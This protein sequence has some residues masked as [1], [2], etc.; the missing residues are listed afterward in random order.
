MPGNPRIQVQMARSSEKIWAE[1]SP[2][3]KEKWTNDTRYT[4]E[5]L[6]MIRFPQ[7][8]VGK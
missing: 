7:K 5:F 2:S 8:H 3:M 1:D 6:Y 4:I